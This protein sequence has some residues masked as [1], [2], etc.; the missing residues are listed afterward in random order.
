MDSLVPLPS[1][2]Q[3][4]MRWTEIPSLGSLWEMT[5]QHLQSN[6]VTDEVCRPEPWFCPTHYPPGAECQGGVL[7]DPHS[8]NLSLAL[9]HQ[10]LFLLRVLL[11]VDHSIS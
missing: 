2:M 3:E 6:K 7:W 8:G 11:G 1:V 9:E 5:I 10:F 4:N